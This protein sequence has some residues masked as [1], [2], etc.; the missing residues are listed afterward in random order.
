MDF[1]VNKMPIEVIRESTFVGTS[2]RDILVLMERGA[3]SH[4]TNLIS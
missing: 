1:G 3:E 2:F 4:G